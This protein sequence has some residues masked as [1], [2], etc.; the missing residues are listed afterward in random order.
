[1]SSDRWRSPAI[2]A[3]A[4]G[5]PPTTIEIRYSGSATAREAPPSVAATATA[6]RTTEA[7]VDTLRASRRQNG[8]CGSPRRRRS[9]SAR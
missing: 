2:A 1:M 8:A 6:S 7:T 3:R 9:G 5:Q 4:I